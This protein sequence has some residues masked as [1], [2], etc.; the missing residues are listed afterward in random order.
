MSPELEN[1]HRDIDCEVPG[2]PADCSCRVGKEHLGW[3]AGWDGGGEMGGGKHSLSSLRTSQGVPL[4]VNS[5]SFR[6]P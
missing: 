5:V 2:S 4:C 1:S 3:L 6:P